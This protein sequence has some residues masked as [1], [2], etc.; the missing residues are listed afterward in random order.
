MAR[1][2]VSSILS[3]A[4]LLTAAASG[5]LRA[6]YFWLVHRDSGKFLFS[7]RFGRP[8]DRVQFLLNIT[9]HADATLFLG[10]YLSLGSQRL[11]GFFLIQHKGTGEYVYGARK[12][13]N[14]QNLFRGALPI[15]ERFLRD[16]GV[17][18]VD[19]R[20]VEAYL[21]ELIDDQRGTGALYV[22]N[23]GTGQ[24]LR[25]HRAKDGLV[26]LFGRQVPKDDRPYR[27][28]VFYPHSANPAPPQA[29]K[30]GGLKRARAQRL[31]A[32]L[33]RAPKTGKADAPKEA[34]DDVSVSI[35]T[36]RSGEFLSG[37][38]AGLP[39]RS[40]RTPILVIRQRY[41]PG[42]NR[43]P[44][45]FQI[46]L[47]GEEGY[48]TIGNPYSGRSLAGAKEARAGD[49]AA[50][51]ALRAEER[52]RFEFDLVEETGGWVAIQHRASSRFLRVKDGQLSFGEAELP[53]STPEGFDE[54]QTY[55]FDIL[56]P[57]AG[58]P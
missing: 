8:E 7:G 50:L 19:L 23:K 34:A 31:V 49:V 6:D 32:G 58:R 20:K 48:V 25:T 28:D 18:D 54:R 14:G 37:M 44:E 57:Y 21:F 12:A 13:S 39:G 35:V 42:R 3:A 45:L 15:D 1:F 41:S 46:A 11:E 16:A 30:A 5:P 4:A 10:R 27:F 9:P 17:E 52:A 36:K 2:F 56:V 38:A 22:K 33:R 51:E 43:V 53:P 47:S 55:L 40:S 29:D 26:E 24:F